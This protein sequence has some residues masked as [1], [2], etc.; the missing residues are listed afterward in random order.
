[1]YSQDPVIL[2]LNQGIPALTDSNFQTFQEI[3]I[4][5]HKKNSHSGRQIFIACPL[6]SAIDVRTI[7][8]TTKLSKHS[9]V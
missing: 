3:I 4:P 7:T 8:F 9:A 1:V 2:T 5:G 6:A